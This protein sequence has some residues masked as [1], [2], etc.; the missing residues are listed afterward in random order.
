MN[1]PFFSGPERIDVFEPLGKPM[2]MGD[3]AALA[4]SD[5][6]RIEEALAD[7]DAD[8]ALG[9]L[10]LIHQNHFLVNA[11][12]LEWCLGLPAALGRAL[13]G[14]AP[15]LGAAVAESWK[16]GVAALN[17]DAATGQ[18]LDGLTAFLGIGGQPL[19]APA[20][21]IERTGRGDFMVAVPAVDTVEI[22]YQMAEAA[23]KDGDYD[24]AAVAVAAYWHA[25]TTLHDAL[26]QYITAFL[27]AV[28][29]A[30]GQAVTQ[31]TIQAS[32]SE[33]SFTK[34][35]MT[36]ARQF[37]AAAKAAFLAEHLRAHLSGADR[38]G[39]TEVSDEGDYY[40]LKFTPCGSGGAQRQR[41][42]AAMP[43]FA[44]ASQVTWGRP[45]EVPLYCAYCAQNEL[46]LTMLL[47]WPALLTDFTPD[48][49]APCYWRL[50]KEGALVPKEYLARV[51]AG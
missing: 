18:V 12:Y 38:A 9:Y 28:N 30:L 35:M 41:L 25:V 45:G 2:R 29:G 32:F 17:T 1:E 19:V 13:G 7:K 16:K 24:G 31:G 44:E 8:R 46:G 10:M 21:F 20:E 11:G 23:I 48:P 27:A 33:M 40:R 6:A 49:Q 50:Y 22:P 15:D 39:A 4:V 5:R 37:S 36:V 47:G 42:G 34:G 14:A 3:F 43:V 51:G 26:A